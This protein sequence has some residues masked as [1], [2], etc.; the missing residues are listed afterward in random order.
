M[1][2]LV[3]SAALLLSAP[4]T[5]A[6]VGD[7]KI[8]MTYNDAHKAGLV[9]GLRHGCPLGGDDTRSARLLPPL[10]GSADLSTSR[11]RTVETI[12]LLGGATARGVGVGSTGRAVRAAF[13]KAR[14]D[15]SSDTTFG[16]TLYRVPKGGGGRMEFGVSTTN[17]RVTVIGVPAL[18]FCD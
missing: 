17:R 6:G 10:K 5:A 18:A 12:L 15:H 1:L 4:I 11:P 2:S 14:I 7:V 16:I 8:G 3:A 9:A 13:P